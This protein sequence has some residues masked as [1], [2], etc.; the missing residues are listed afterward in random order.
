MAR[1]LPVMTSN[2]YT[3]TDR[4][5][6]FERAQA[7]DFPRIKLFNMQ[8]WNVSLEEAY[9]LRKLNDLKFCEEWLDM[10]DRRATGGKDWA[11][12]AR[13][14]TKMARETRAHLIAKYNADML[15]EPSEPEDD[16]E[17]LAMSA[18]LTME[19]LARPLISL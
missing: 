6:A 1:S 4:A 12:W 2:K 5:L 8:V 18:S 3:M 11:M 7:E 15:E 10:V 14:V 19:A 13:L 16:S 17:L 9:C